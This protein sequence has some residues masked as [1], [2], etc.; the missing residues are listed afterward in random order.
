MIAEEQRTTEIPVMIDQTPSEKYAAKKKA[1][2]IA[3]LAKAEDNLDNLANYFAG[4][5]PYY[6]DDEMDVE[7]FITDMINVR[8]RL[9]DK[10]HEIEKS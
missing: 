10:R 2:L 8:D 4:D 3:A 7:Q 5:L 9:Q 6:A 1:R